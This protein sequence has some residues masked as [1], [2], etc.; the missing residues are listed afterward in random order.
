MFAHLQS[1]VLVEEGPG[2]KTITLVVNRGTQADGTSLIGPTDSPATVSYQL[3]SGTASYGEDFTGQNAGN[4]GFPVNSTEQTV[5]V[6]ILDDDVPEMEETFFVVLADPNGDVVLADPFNLTVAIGRSD[7]PNGV[8]HLGIRGAPQVPV[9][10]VNE[11]QQQ[12]LNVTV[13]RSDGT[14]GDV[15]IQWEI[16]RVGSD[17]DPVTSDLGPSQGMFALLSG[18]T[19]ATVVLSIIQDF[20]PEPSEKFMFRL[21]PETVTGGARLE[22]PESIEIVITDS[23]SAYGV[24]AMGPDSQ[25]RLI[26]VSVYQAFIIIKSIQQVHNDLT[27]EQRQF[28]NF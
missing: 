2:V 13:F 10:F 12:E 25:Q 17:L 14:F 23:D 5:I 7:D 6:E 28:L 19:S 4:I 22:V 11:D 1:T 18:E 3:I 27:D 8:L 20:D 15:S 16:T 21:L 26:T 24:V 9:S